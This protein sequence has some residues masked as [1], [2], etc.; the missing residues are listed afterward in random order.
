MSH[1]AAEIP[2]Q[3][4]RPRFHRADAVPATVPV[5]VLDAIGAAADAYDALHASGRRVHFG[6]GGPA[7]GL[8]IQMLDTDGELLGTVSPRELLDLA[9]G[10]PLH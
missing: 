5:E 6:L 4:H 2:P 10:A 8:T 3:Q 7:G 9:A 1:P